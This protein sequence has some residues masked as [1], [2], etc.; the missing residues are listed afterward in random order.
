M[1]LKLCIFILS[2]LTL[3]CWARI[4]NTWHDYQTL[5]VI[6]SEPYIKNKVLGYQMT[7]AIIAV[8]TGGKPMNG[9]SGERG[10]AQF[11]PST[12]KAYQ[13]IH[14]GTTTLPMTPEN[15]IELLTIHNT[16]LLSKGYTLSQL[17][18]AHNAGSPTATCR[19][20]VNK[21]GVKFDCPSYVKKVL[22]EYSKLCKVR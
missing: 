8:E 13:K 19:K 21:Y 20:G 2:I 15:E 10:I 17:A 5:K 7:R 18:V 22:S 4:L 3:I 16:Y 11:I 1:K 14:L 6:K 12:F 9:Q